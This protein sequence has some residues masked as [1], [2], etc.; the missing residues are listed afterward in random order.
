MQEVVGSNPADF[1]KIFIM[2]INLD[3]LVPSLIA[4]GAFCVLTLWGIW[5]LIDWIWIDDVIK[6]DHLI[7]PEIELVITED[8]RVDTVYIY[9]NPN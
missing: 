3:G 6:S 4:F 2:G 8:N 7:V 1:S 5:L 9:H